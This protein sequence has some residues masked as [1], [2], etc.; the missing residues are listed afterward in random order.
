WKS[1]VGFSWLKMYAQ[2]PIESLRFMDGFL[3]RVMPCLQNPQGSQSLAQ[4][5]ENALV[6]LLHERTRGNHFFLALSRVKGA[7]KPGSPSLCSNAGGR[8][9][10][11][12]KEQILSVS[13]S[14]AMMPTTRR[15]GS[16]PSV[17]VTS[18]YAGFL[19]RL[20]LTLPTPILAS[21]T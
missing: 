6:S 9:F 20:S 8:F 18:K 15:P 2:L 7:K 1:F 16:R 19:V 11:W 4:R 13:P 10:S 21:P 12:L 5:L 14:M 3:G 17:V